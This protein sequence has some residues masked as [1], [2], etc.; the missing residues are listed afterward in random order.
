MRTDELLSAIRL[1]AFLPP[2]HKTYTDARLLIEA[3]NALT[4]IFERN[5]VN[6]RQGY[7]LKSTR[8]V[9]TVGKSNYPIPS[10]AIVG[11][12]EK[13]E[14]TDASGQYQPIIQCTQRDAFMYEGIAGTTTGVPAR[15]VLAGDQVRLLPAPA[16]VYTLRFT[17]YVRPSR[18][19]QPQSSTLAPI[20]NNVD[21]GQVTAVNPTARTIVVNVV[22]FDQELAVPAALTTA[23]QLIDVVHK[24]GVWHELALVGAPQTLA[25]VTF[26]VGG[27]DDMNEIR[28]GD[29]VRVAEQTDWPCLPDDFH[30][31]LADAAGAVI[32]TALNI[33]NK[34]M[35]LSQKVNTDIAR[36]T[37]LLTPR[38]KNSPRTILARNALIR[39][40]GR[41][42][43]L[44]R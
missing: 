40:S 29:Y 8:Q 6:S 26:T 1:A 4:T 24:D 23:V 9:T 19:V 17:Y 16:G 18:L 7:W 43:G 13:L 5:V 27:T 30:R 41:R 39:R 31:T 33:I 2:S 3:Q 12:L 15:Y 21:R 44:N 22:P 34:S 25:G 28:V 20:P 37:D 38:V 10:R 14:I 36:F 42:T 35:A 32:L 11:G